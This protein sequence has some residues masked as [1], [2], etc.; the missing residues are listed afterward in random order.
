MIQ[1]HS[2]DA[3]T[4]AGIK[5]EFSASKRIMLTTHK[6]PDGDAIGS[7]LALYQY[8]KEMGH[9]VYVSVPDPAP[10]FLHWLPHFDELI[11][12]QKD[13]DY[14]KEVLNECD[15]LIALDYNHF[16][17]TGS[18]LGKLLSDSNALKI[19]IDHHQEP[20]DFMKYK[21]WD[22]EASSTAQLVYDLIVGLSSEKSITKSIGECLYTGIMTDTG[23]FRFA[24]CSSHTMRIVAHLLDCGVDGNNIHHL[25]YDQNSKDRLHLMGYALKKMVMIDDFHTAYISLSKEELDNFNYKAGDTEGLVNKILS[26]KGVKVAALITEKEGNIRFS[27]RSSAEF[28]VNAFA[29]K[30]FSGG[31]HYHAAGGNISNDNIKEACSLFESSIKLYKDELEL[32]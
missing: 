6:S 32:A 22:V 26:V 19:L 9:E 3:K 17:R 24:T 31:G 1:L 29:R 10:A 7:S 8:L 14:F 15:I 20:D 25:V 30:H 16:A 11:T 5:E 12:Y 21:V 23:S 13:K 2:I 4:L 28:S 18:E 27:F